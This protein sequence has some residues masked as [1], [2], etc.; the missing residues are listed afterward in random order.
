MSEGLYSDTIN[1][2]TSIMEHEYSKTRDIMKRWPKA[3]FEE[4]LRI[5]SDVM[6]SSKFN[7]DDD[8]YVFSDEISKALMVLSCKYPEL[9]H[10][11]NSG[12]NDN[13]SIHFDDY[14]PFLTACKYGNLDMI[15]DFRRFQ[16]DEEDGSKMIPDDIW[17]KGASI[18]KKEGED[19]VHE[20]IKK[21]LETGTDAE[22]DAS[23]VSSQSDDYNDCGED[24]DE[25]EIAIYEETRRRLKEIR[26]QE[27]ATNQS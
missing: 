26:Q 13:V 25:D 8:D 14:K 27:R 18:A 24:E 6:L 10:V 17:K 5:I 11:W 22:D 20:W 23:S 19:A 21:Y 7:G 3:N 9:D 15:K 2:T 16:Y 12:I 4:M 1:L